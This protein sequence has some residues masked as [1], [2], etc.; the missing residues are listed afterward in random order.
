MCI[1]GVQPSHGR[2]NQV[3]F[4]FRVFT[5]K[6]AHV[7]SPPSPAKFLRLKKRKISVALKSI[8]IHM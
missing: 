5:V 7:A 1:K 6:E 8:T 2:E 4:G 3:G